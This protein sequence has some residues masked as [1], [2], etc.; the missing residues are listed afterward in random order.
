M[1]AR[2]TTWPM[3][4]TRDPGGA[5][6]VGMSLVPAGRACTS[7]SAFASSR[8]SQ[9]VSCYKNPKKTRAQAPEPAACHFLGLRKPRKQRPKIAEI[10]VSREPSKPIQPESKENRKFSGRSA[11]AQKDS[12]YNSNTNPN[13]FQVALSPRRA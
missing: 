9:C 11:V 1:H 8:L 10:T 13:F 7:A 6:T 5:H 3:N 4:E 12:R 2:S